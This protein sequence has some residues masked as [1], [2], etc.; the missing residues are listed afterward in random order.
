M[1]LAR[2]TQLGIARA[3]HQPGCSRWESTIKDSVCGPCRS[4][5]VQS[6]S[7]HASPTALE[8]H[9]TGANESG[10][11]FQSPTSTVCY[12]M[13]CTDSAKLASEQHVELPLS[14]T[15]RSTCQSAAQMQCC[16]G[17]MGHLMPHDTEG[18]HT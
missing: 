2:A 6:E 16:T 7:E 18:L 8:R 12:A 13:C 11:R 14:D 4:L 15:A 9:E 5:Q 1:G 10:L 17:S 3:T